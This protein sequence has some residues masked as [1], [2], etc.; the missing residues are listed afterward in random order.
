MDFLLVSISCII[1][2]TVVGDM[3]DLVWEHGEKIRSGFICKYC[4]EV[5]SGGGATTHLKEHLAHRGMDMKN[6]PSLPLDIKR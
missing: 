3:Q 4:R 1:F 2:C 5:K 6:Y